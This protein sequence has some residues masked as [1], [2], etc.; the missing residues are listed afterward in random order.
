MYY[1]FQPIA[2]AVSYIDVLQRLFSLLYFLDWWAITYW[3]CVVQVF[4]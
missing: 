3:G 1:T 4:Y 2:A